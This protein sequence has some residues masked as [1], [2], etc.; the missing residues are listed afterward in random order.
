VLNENRALAAWEIASMCLS[1]LLAAWFVAPMSG[2]AGWLRVVPLGL[3]VALIFVS[4]RA[5]GE[6]WREIGW[7]WDNFPAAA[8]LLAGPTLASAAFFVFLGWRFDTLRLARENFASWAL[9]LPFWAL[10]QQTLLQG[11]VNRRAQILWGL[12]RGSI[13]LTAAVFALLHAPNPG[14]TLMTFAGGLIWSWAYQR[15]PNLFAM[16]LSHA[17]LALVLARS[18]GPLL[19]N[20]RVGIN[21]FW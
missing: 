6:T 9:W 21:Y 14:L 7:R 13:L 3:A 15:V 1:F 19:K 12:G 8:R 11:Y 18:L 16:T 17:F 20:L 2:G 4:H 10:L 5:R